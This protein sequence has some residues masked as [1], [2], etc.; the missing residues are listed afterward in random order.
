MVSIYDLVYD[1]I[2]KFFQDERLTKE[3]KKTIHRGIKKLLALGWCSEEI[4][5]VF[6]QFKGKPTLDVERLFKG[7]K[8]SSINLI[9][10][11]IF[12]YHNDLR[13]TC[14]PPKREMDYETGEIRS[15]NEPYFLEM[16]A[17]YTVENLVDY[18]LRQVGTHHKKDVN[19]F[20]GSFKWLLKSYKVEEILFMIDACVNTAKSEDLSLPESPLDIQKHHR[21]A[22]EN[23][24]LK[25][26]HTI[27]AGGNKIVRKKRTRRS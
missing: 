20:I 9:H 10:P 1:Y 2:E 26:T 16:K 15:V 6:K 25:R 8:K 27:Q 19:R 4:Q 12:Y 22:L 5:R 24:N 14:A 18:Y 11:N 23:W 3:E 17:S 21:I 7:K 13:L